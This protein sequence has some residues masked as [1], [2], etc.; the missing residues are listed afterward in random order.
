MIKLELI[1]SKLERIF[2]SKIT[3]NEKTIS[4]Q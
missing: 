3:E 1:T 2:L 4:L